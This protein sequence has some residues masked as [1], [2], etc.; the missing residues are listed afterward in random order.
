MISLTRGRNRP[1]LMA[2]KKKRKKR[3]EK[4]DERRKEGKRRDKKWRDT[5]ATPEAAVSGVGSAASL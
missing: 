3:R 5:G 2:G 4:K 1:G